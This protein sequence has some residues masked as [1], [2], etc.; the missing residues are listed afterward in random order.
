MKLMKLIFQDSAPTGTQIR[1][2]NNVVTCFYLIKFAKVNCF[3]IL[4]LKKGPPQL[5]QALDPLKPNQSNLERCLGWQGV[6][7]DCFLEFNLVPVDSGLGGEY[8][9]VG[10]WLSFS[11]VT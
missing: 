2:T 6:E 8:P 5:V 3:A 9:A 11:L 10:V 1:D 4:F 7:E